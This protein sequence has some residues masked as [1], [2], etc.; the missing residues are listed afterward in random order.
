MSREAT[1][2]MVTRVIIFFFIIFFFMHLYSSQGCGSC[3]NLSGSGH[4][5]KPGPDPDPIFQKKTGSGSDP[6]KTT[7]IWI[8]ISP[9]LTL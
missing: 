5:E 2:G 6:R 3:W 9:N 4:Q 8:R 7:R 1:P